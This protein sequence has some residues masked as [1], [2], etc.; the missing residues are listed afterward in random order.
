MG[1]GVPLPPHVRRSMLRGGIAGRDVAP[2]HFHNETVE[3]I[4]ADEILTGS[5]K[6][7]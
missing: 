2:Y 7:P 6:A 5:L 4:P 3:E 1:E